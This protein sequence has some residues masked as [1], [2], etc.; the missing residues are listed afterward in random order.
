M[1][2]TLLQYLAFIFVG[3]YNHYSLDN[4]MSGVEKEKGQDAA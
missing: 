2:K 3:K 1:S 4:Y